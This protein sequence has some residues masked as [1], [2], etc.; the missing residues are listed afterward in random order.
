MPNITQKCRVTGKSFVV[1]EW[2]QEFLKKFDLPIPTLSIAER[3]RMRLAQRNERRIY[4]DKCDLTGEDII[5]LYSEDKLYKVYSQEAWW[6]DGWD[7]KDYGRD[8]DFDRPFFEQFAE[9]RR[10]V[11]RL[12][13]MNTNGENSEYCNITTDNKNCYLVFGGDFNE[14]AVNSIYCFYCKDVSDLF[15]VQKSELT[16][17]CVGCTNAYQLKYS[18]DSSGCSDSSFLFQCKNLKN[19]FGCVNL[20]GKEYHI[21]NKAYSPEEYEA[22]LKEFK[23]NTW[24]GVQHM[25]NEF[26]KFKKQ[27]PFK[28]ANIVNSEN[29]TG[30]HIKNAKNCDNCFSVEGP[31][32]DL[33]DVYVAIDLK[34]SLSSASCGFKGELYY[35]MLGSIAGVRC[36]LSNFIWHSNDVFYSDMCVNSND[37]FGC[38]N[39]RRDKYCILNKQYS[40]EEY[41][42]LREKI[43]E[44]MKKTGEWGEPFPMEI[45][46]WAYN[47]T[48]AND[49]FPL[50]KAKVLDN[51]LKWK[52]EELGQP[53]TGPAIPDA[54]ED[55]TDEVL[56]QSLICEKTGRPYR[57]TPAELKLCRQMEVPVP[58]F[59]PETR[60]EMRMAM[61]NPISTWDR[62]C[63]K[64]GAEIK[65]SYSPERPETIYCEKCYLETVY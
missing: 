6:G 17:D 48:V 47:E 3:H 8:F 52:D 60:N 29:V 42:A 37:L 65:T 49:F 28:F 46:P 21:F 62:N 34:S 11:P 9:L 33:K 10:A 15:W 31:A 27:F 22:K 44:H 2:E 35:E 56:K 1:T 55:V 19:C 64:C 16:Y 43:V 59:A 53:G 39:L 57:I 26:E 54:I 25:K 40:K 63:D 23:L 30:D 20:N 24:S 45:S 12:S 7:A 58:H 50:E 41:F 32:E 13:L 38:S 4:R 61:R 5:S 36:A 18:Q 51:G 14:D